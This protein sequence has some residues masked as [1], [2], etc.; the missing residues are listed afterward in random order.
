MDEQKFKKPQALFS[1]AFQTCSIAI[2]SNTYILETV[3]TNEQVKSYP[4]CRDLIEKAF[5]FYINPTAEECQELRKRSC[6]FRMKTNYNP[7]VIWHQ[8]K[9]RIINFSNSNNISIF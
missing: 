3:A 2:Y 6:F 1:H 9:G 8:S 4:E 5:L 7:V